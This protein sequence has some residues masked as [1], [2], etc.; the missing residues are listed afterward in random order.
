MGRLL[1]VR[2]GESEWNAERRWQGWHDVPLS[3]RGEAQA[4]RAAEQLRW[5]L[6]NQV[7]RAVAASDLAR[8]RQTAEILTEGL[9]L[10]PVL[11]DRR[12][13]ER[14]VG[15]WSGLTEA[16]VEARFPG[17]LGRWR[18]GELD[19]IPGGESNAEVLERALAAVR[20][21]RSGPAD[22]W[23]IA[24]THGGLI[25]VLERHVGVHSER[26]PN[27]CGR[28]LHFEGTEITGGETFVLEDGP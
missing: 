20:D 7:V 15:E 26:I 2:H 3:P 23:T 25:R 24:V 21:L 12:L 28:W 4:K 27:L 14:N 8:A 10:G 13:R 5:L 9:G 17:M 19:R 16:E 6:A 11:T 18:T 22:G 1:L